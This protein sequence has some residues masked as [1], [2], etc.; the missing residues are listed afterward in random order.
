MT[1]PP[2]PVEKLLAFVAGLTAR[3]RAEVEAW[4]MSAERQVESVKAAL[5]AK[6]AADVLGSAGDVPGFRDWPVQLPA[7][8][9]ARLR[10]SAPVRLAKAMARLGRPAEV[11][12]LAVVAGKSAAW[13]YPLLAHPWFSCVRPGNRSGVAGLYDLTGAGRAAMAAEPEKAGA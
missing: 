3:E 8:L 9:P 11:T 1:A 4:L 13:V 2:P 12:E 7:T 10:G 5:R 6:A